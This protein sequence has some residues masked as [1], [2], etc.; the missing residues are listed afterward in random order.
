MAE[1]AGVIIRKGVCLKSDDDIIR[2]ALLDKVFKLDR[3]LK[4]EKMSP[5]DYKTLTDERDRTFALIDKFSR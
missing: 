4:H 2:Q 5:I 3:R 1:I